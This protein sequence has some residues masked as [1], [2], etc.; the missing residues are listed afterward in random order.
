M[1]LSTRPPLTNSLLLSIVDQLPSNLSQITST[2]TL[3]TLP[4]L[5]RHH[6]H[7]LAY[8]NAIMFCKF[9]QILFSLAILYGHHVNTVCTTSFQPALLFLSFVK[10][11][12]LVCSSP[13]QCFNPSCVL[14]SLRRYYPRITR[15]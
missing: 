12:L 11:L 8:L 13:S 10:V 4:S 15:L 7:S 6:T 9:S 14:F 5:V 1:Q 3:L 2:R